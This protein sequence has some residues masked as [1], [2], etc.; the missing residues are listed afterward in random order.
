M[1]LIKV[2][3]HVNEMMAVVAH[4]FS[5]FFMVRFSYNQTKHLS[6]VPI[7]VFIV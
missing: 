3:E 1:I 5:E 7:V 6:N 2:E 4:F